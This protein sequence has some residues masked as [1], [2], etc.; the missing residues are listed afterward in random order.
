NVNSQEVTPGYWPSRQSSSFHCLCSF[1]FREPVSLDCHHSFCSSCL[2]KYWDQTKNKNCLVCKRK[3]SKDAAIHFSLKELVDKYVKQ[4]AVG[5]KSTER[6]IRGELEKLHQF[7]REEEEARLTARRE[8][9]KE[10]GKMITREKEHSGPD[11]LSYRNHPCCET[12]PAETECVI[13]QELQTHPD[14]L[15]SPVHTARS[16]AGLRSTGRC[17]KTPGK[18]A[19][20]SLEEDTKDCQVHSCD[21]GLQYC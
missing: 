12:E 2:D 4:R 20:H 17:G 18:S 11:H 8:E 9:E 5:H 19:V 1:T 14:K 7:L 13:S 16:T 15:Q 6:Q 3:S 21:S 10:K